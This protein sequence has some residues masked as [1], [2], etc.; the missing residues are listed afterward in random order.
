MTN[1]AFNI[2][3]SAQA[4]ALAPCTAQW[5]P[6]RPGS[7]YEDIFAAAEKMGGLKDEVYTPIPANVALYDRLYADYKLL[8]DYFGRGGTT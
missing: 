6:V 7:G 4:A 1:R 3:K 5:P 2:V 8:Y